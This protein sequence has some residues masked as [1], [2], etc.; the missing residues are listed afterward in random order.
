MPFPHQSP[1]HS[2]L[3]FHLVMHANVCCNS[4]RWPA[5]ACLSHQTCIRN[6]CIFDVGLFMLPHVL[7][8]VNECVSLCVSVCLCVF[9]SV[10]PGP[11]GASLTGEM[12]LH[13]PTHRERERSL[14]HIF[15]RTNDQ[16]RNVLPSIMF[17]C[18]IHVIGSNFVTVIQSFSH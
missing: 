14:T 3:C 6:R 2:P 18:I 11:A 12:R 13:A 17:K 4:E 8:C 15:G 7:E 10:L 1:S 16:C 9:V 5:A